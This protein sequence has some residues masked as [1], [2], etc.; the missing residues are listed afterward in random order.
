MRLALVTG[1][2][3]G[4][5]RAV[6][7]RLAADG[8]LVAVNDREPGPAL[9]LLAAEVGGIA[10]PAD[11]SDPGAVRRM[12]GDITGQAGTGVGV[13][14][15]NAA[16]M[17]MAPLAEHDLS[18]W[19]RVVDVCLGGAFACVQA[20]LPGM[21]SRGGGRIVLVASEWGL[22][23]WPGASAYSAA[24]A[25]LIALTKSLG[26]ELGPDGITVN[27]IAPSVIDTGQLDVDARDA[28]VSPAEIR[29][30]YAARV[31]LGRIATPAEIAAS[32]AF[33][34][35]ERMSSLTGQIVHVDG[36]ATRAR[37]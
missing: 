16:Y 30:R 25:G 26:R 8:A 10:A 34:A 23:G 20:V 15:A 35:D 2:A 33:L 29:A 7:H 18:D 14:V 6:A 37:A 13:L 1:A 12:V 3:G 27:A 4:L 19:W 36:G 28:G 17:T 32:V 24:K 5:G 31:P 11:V 21:R 9:D 22:I